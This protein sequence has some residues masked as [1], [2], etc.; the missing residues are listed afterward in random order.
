MPPKE[1][2]EK[3]PRSK[4]QLAHMEKLIAMNKERAK[5]KREGTKPVKATKKKV[6]KV[7]EPEPES[8]EDVPDYASDESATSLI[9][10]ASSLDEES[11]PEEAKEEEPEPEPEKPKPKRKPRIRKCYK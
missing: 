1:K 5:V 6:K 10:L 8:D 11:E 9:A 7:V 4:A 3:K 2:K